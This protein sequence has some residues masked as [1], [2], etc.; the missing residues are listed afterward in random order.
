MRYK[1][2]LNNQ[3]IR[4]QSGEGLHKKKIRKLI[5]TNKI[6]IKQMNK[7]IRIL[8]KKNKN[9]IMDKLKNHKLLI[10]F[11]QMKYQ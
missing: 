5:R 1:E 11:G 9:K 2:Q 3:I 8:G 10:N 7:K 6:Q 4:D